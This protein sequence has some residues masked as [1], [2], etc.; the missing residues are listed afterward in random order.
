MNVF[1]FCS[2]YSGKTRYTTGYDTPIRG[3][4]K[5]FGNQ[6]AIKTENFP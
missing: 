1:G 4:P 5:I 3:F 6:N 2:N